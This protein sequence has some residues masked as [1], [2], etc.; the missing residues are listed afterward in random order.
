M[1]LKNT[2]HGEEMTMY[3]RTARVLA[4]MLVLCATV[5]LLFCACA[6]TAP[7]ENGGVAP[8]PP[9]KMTLEVGDPAPNFTL[10]TMKSETV[11]LSQ[12]RGKPVLLIFW[13]VHCE[14]CIHEIPYIQEFYDKHADEVVLLAV[15]VG[16]ARDQIQKLLSTR[17]IT[18]PILIDADEQVCI[19]YRHGAPAAF[20]IDKEGTIKAVKEETFLNVSEIEAMLQKIK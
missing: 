8:P 1:A 6:R 9:D 7:Q 13:V 12:Y 5:A 2:S 14:G 3:H 10:Q 15:H 4:V 11:T 19:S 20:A 16:D 18:Y 17:R